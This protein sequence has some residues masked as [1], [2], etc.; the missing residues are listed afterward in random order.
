MKK[1]LL[2]LLLLPVLGFAQTKTLLSTN[3]VFPKNDKQA[4]FEKGL[5][6]HAQK[7]HKGDVAWR[8]WSIESGPD[9][10]GYMITEGPTTWAVMDGRGDLGAAHTA[11]WEQ[12]VLIHT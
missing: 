6:S 11:D 4:A 9:A 10:G 8:V 2:F 3:R 7:Y 12:N 1:F 5:A